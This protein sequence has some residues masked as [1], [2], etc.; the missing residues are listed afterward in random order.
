MPSCPIWAVSRAQS[1][2]ELSQ[3]GVF[4]KY[5]KV[6]GVQIDPSTRRD[7]IAFKET[8]N[9]LGIEMPRS[10]PAYSIEE[11]ETIAAELGFPLVIRPA[12]TMGARRGLVYIVEE[13]RIVATRHAASLWGNPVEESVLGWEE[14]S[15]KCVRDAQNG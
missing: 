2:S 15:W 14:R 10:K 12:Y 9:R 8:M 6:I 1:W 3:A 13:L 11:A 5:V 4:E 7:R